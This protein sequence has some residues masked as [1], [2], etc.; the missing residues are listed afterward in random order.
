MPLLFIDFS[1]ITKTMNLTQF[2]FSKVKNFVK[3]PNQLDVR[4]IGIFFPK[5]MK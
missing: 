2:K 3:N 5:K 1:D 4:K